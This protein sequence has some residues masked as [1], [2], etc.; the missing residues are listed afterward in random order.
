MFQM[1]IYEKVNLSTPYPIFC[2]GDDS[3]CRGF[4]LNADVHSPVCL[5]PPHTIHELSG[6]R[7]RLWKLTSQTNWWSS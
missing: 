4:P 5:E 2:D 1:R 6:C 7:C 3:S